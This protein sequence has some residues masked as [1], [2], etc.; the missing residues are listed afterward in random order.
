MAFTKKSKI[1]LIIVAVPLVL[2]AAAILA[3]ELLFTSSKLKAMIVPRIEEATHRSVALNDIGLTLFPA[4]GVRIDGLSISNRKGDGFSDAPFISLDHLRL[5]VKIIPLLSGNLEISSITVDRPRILV[6]TNSANQTNYADL[7]SP[8]KT[9]AGAPPAAGPPTKGGSENA[10]VLLISDL[11][12]TNGAVDYVNYKDNSATR[13]RGLNVGLSL[14]WEAGKLVILSKGSIDSLSYGGVDDALISGLRL[15]FAPHLVYEMQSDLLTIE[16]GP[17]TVQDMS[18]TFGGKVKDVRKSMELDLS[19]GSDQLNIADLLSLVPKEYMKKAEGLSGKGTVAAHISITGIISDSSSADI[20]GTIS[21]QGASIQYAKLPKPISNITIQT[22]FVRSKANQ[23]FR[24]E[25]FTANLGDNPI[26]MTL[27][28]HNFADPSVALSF[29]GAMNL[30]DVD[31]FYPLEKGTEL[32][33][34]LSSDISVA[35]RIKDPNG[36]RASGTMTFDGVTAK[37]S[38]SRRPV[39]NVNGSI[40]FNNQIIESKNLTMTIGGSDLSLAFWLKNYLSLMSTDKNAPRPTANLTLQSKHLNTADIMGNPE[41]AGPGQGAGSPGAPRA[42]AGAPGG[43]AVK[44]SSQQTTLPFPNMEM[45]VSGSVGT[46]TM[47][48][49]EFTNV[50]MMMHIANGIVTMQNFSLD[51]FGG[52]VISKGSVN[53]QKPGRPLFDISLDINGVEANT[54]LPHFTSFGSRLKGRMTMNTAMKGALND[55]LGL[56]P[57]TLDGNGR[58]QIQNG[59]LDG[60]KVNEAIASALK[61]PDLRTINF[62]DWSNRFVI[63]NGRV[64]IKDL[65]ISALNA[66]YVVNG[67]QGIDGSLDYATTLFLP[68]SASSKVSVGGFAGEALNAF[69]DQSGRLKFDFNIGGTTDDPK[70]QLNTEGPRKRVEELAKQKLQDEAKKVGEQAKQKAGDLL[71]NI[72]KKGKK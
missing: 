58:V 6:E 63:Q 68:E 71:K 56:I 50:R 19:V 44:G 40:A 25:K 21:G 38:S 29:R 23:E 27:T 60:F 52:S 69:K 47:Q 57:G 8:E 39:Q 14:Q 45:D 20:R 36:I 49:F 46:F 5:N 2:I 51:A 59:S 65:K 67:S 64:L 54:L 22:D 48:K 15:S 26:A 31:Q 53:M 3:V 12:L 1:I 7:T 13:I 70:V 17:M 9:P 34:K 4:I 72:F 42:N 62:K 55:T 43:T 11:N 33:G 37:T 24:V 10:G 16:P 35:G 28:V 18:L 30:A 32:S 66:D 61:L 41:E